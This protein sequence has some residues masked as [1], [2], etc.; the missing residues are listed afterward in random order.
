MLGEYWALVL[1]G[2]RLVGP[3]IAEWMV[4]PG[5][6]WAFFGG[7][8]GAASEDPSCVCQVRSP[9]AIAQIALIAHIGLSSGH[10]GQAPARCVQ[11]A[12]RA[13]G[14]RRVYLVMRYPRSTLGVWACR[15]GYR[16]L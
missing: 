5:R 1:Q 10:P 13:P 15:L 16:T 11:C 8:R 3:L 12:M 7:V 2:C 4:G 14:R 9:P 6:S